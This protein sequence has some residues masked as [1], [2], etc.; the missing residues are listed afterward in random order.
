MEEL[1]KDL[2]SNS[3]QNI[4]AFLEANSFNSVRKNC[5]LLR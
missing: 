2:I 5:T 1:L 3:L 4:M